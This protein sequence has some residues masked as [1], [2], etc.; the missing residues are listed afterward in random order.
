MRACRIG[1]GCNER[2]PP[3]IDG[4]YSTRFWANRP[5]D[6]SPGVSAGVRAAGGAT[7]RIQLGRGSSNDKTRPMACPSTHLLV[8]LYSCLSMHV[9][10][11]LRLR[12][13]IRTR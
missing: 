7:R 3:G 11:C 10:L 4:A 8:D 2:C 9:S 1:A 12:V 13:C 5:E 6:A